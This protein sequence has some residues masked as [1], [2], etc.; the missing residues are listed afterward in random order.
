MQLTVK[1]SLASHTNISLF[2]NYLLK[3]LDC[4][5]W[6]YYLEMLTF[7]FDWEVRFLDFLTVKDAT[8]PKNT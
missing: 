2:R 5:V 7:L 6:A 4:Q 3:V 1:V 8:H